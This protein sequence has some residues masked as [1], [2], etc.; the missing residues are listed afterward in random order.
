MLYFL[1]PREGGAMI[2][3]TD[4]KN[5][6]MHK[7]PASLKPPAINKHASHVQ[8]KANNSGMMMERSIGDALSIALMSQNL[9]QRVLAISL[10]L[11]NIAA[12]A[13]ATGKI[14]TMEM[15]DA[16]SDIK[17]ALGGFGESV[18]A[19]L[20]SST[21]AP[22]AGAEMPDLTNEMK[23]IHDIAVDLKGGSANVADRI[24]ILTKNL[25]EKSRALKISEQNTIKLMGE[26]AP[27]NAPGNVNSQELISR[28]KT[29]IEKNPA[30]ALFIQGNISHR[31]AGKFFV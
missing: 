21:G 20:L 29:D 1:P 5:I 28:I 18:A 27:D 9:I 13:L 30:H 25:N 8:H 3:R 7:P 26:T 23:S 11:K 19:P 15:N 24:D 17:N 6:S 4:L 31:A 12:D 10:R 14:N 16:M 2:I 22:V